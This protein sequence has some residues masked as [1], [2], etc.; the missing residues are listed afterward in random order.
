MDRNT[1]TE[2]EIE[3]FGKAKELQEGWKPRVGDWFYKA[4]GLG[5]GTWL[6][7]IIMGS[8]LFCAGK[9]MLGPVFKNRLVEFR[10]PQNYTWIASIEQLWEMVIDITMRDSINQNGTLQKWVDKYVLYANEFN[11]SMKLLLLAFVMQEKYHRKW[12]GKTWR[13]LPKK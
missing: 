13:K 5:H 12:N 2:L 4:D 8:T 11:A 10:A 3:M 1:K 6:I 7:C 9:R